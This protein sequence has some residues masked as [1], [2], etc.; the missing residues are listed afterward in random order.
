M[1]NKQSL[2]T[3]LALFLFGVLGIAAQDLLEIIENET[4]A[5][6]MYTQATFKGNRVVL[7]QSVE[8]RKKGT[9]EFLL[10]TR[11]WNTPNNDASQSFGADKFSAHFG[12]QYAF[13]DRF[14]LGAGIGSID[15]SFNSF[16]K[17]RLVRQR[18]DKNVPLSITLVQGLSYFS[19][20]FGTFTLPNNSAERLSYISQAII[21]RKFNKNLS[22]QFSPS[23][24]NMGT[25][26]PVPEKN[27]LFLLGFGGR[28]KLSNHVSLAG[29]YGY[30]LGRN[31]ND[32]GFNLFGLGVNWE[33][34]DLIMH[35]SFT[36]SKNFDDIAIY[37]F[38]PNNFHFRPGGLHI[39][40]NATYILHTKK[41]KS[42]SLKKSKE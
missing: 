40:V 30:L 7:T 9:L 5:M 16:A 34:G 37:S 25:D 20:N 26:Q 14:T 41:R 15:G 39:G 19:K 35:F 36:N 27:D 38:N 6:P 18:E 42:K 23:Y 2:V 32:Q 22:L 28:Y 24:I 17:Y 13:S 11:Y 29:E 3:T 8:T 10:S 21:A 4:P 33:L 31:E 12:M 1:N